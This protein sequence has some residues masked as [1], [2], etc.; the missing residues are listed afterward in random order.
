MRIIVICRIKEGILTVKSIKNSY[1]FEMTLYY[2]Q[3]QKEFD[4]F[5]LSFEH[6][7]ETITKVDKVIFGYES[8]KMK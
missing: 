3:D 2:N 5:L 4:W 1:S 8:I 6:S 7:L